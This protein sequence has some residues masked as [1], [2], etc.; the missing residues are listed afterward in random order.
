ML[1]LAGGPRQRCEIAHTARDDREAVCNRCRGDHPIEKR[2]ELFFPLERHNE[3]CQM[4]TY[5][6]VPR[7]AM[8][9]ARQGSK[10]SSSFARLRPR[11]RAS[12]PMESSPRMIE[13]TASL[14]SLRASSAALRLPKRYGGGMQANTFV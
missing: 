4:P 6:K 8:N 11:G 10:H 2:H 9:R 12:T 3:V 7:R 1:G 5:G 14:R 13:S